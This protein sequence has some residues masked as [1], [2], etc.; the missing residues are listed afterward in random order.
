MK[1]TLDNSMNNKKK[2]D[3][4]VFPGGTKF[5]GMNVPV[6]VVLKQTENAKRKIWI[7][8]AGAVIALAAAAVLIYFFC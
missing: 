1:K 8:V 2:A 6:T 5:E 3:T 4:C 7:F